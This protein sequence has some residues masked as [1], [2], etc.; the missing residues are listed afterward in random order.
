MTPAHICYGGKGHDFGGP[1]QFL[2]R[3][4]E[5]ALAVRE[6]RQRRMS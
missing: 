4:F 5:L 2:A 3:V 1:L 6:E